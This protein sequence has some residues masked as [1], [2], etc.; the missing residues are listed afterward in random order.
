MQ[1]QSQNQET[2]QEVIRAHLGS[3]GLCYALLMA[4]ELNPQRL[5]EILPLQGL[6]NVAISGYGN[7]CICARETS[8]KKL[9]SSQPS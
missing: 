2:V 3:T 7:V 8:I 9:T 4:Q 5:L 1:L 6:L